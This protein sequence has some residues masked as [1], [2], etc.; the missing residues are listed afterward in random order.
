MEQNYTHHI[1]YQRE[2]ERRS[3][4]AA[5]ALALLHQ[6][7]KENVLR[8]QNKTANQISFSTISGEGEEK[9]RRWQVSAATK[10]SITIGYRVGSSTK[11][12]ENRVAAHH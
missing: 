5:I 9:E 4:W 7:S 3:E 11:N 1:L 12:E 8:E 10:T 2:G 6:R